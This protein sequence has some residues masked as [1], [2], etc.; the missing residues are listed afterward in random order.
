MWSQSSAPLGFEVQVSQLT[1][2]TCV[3]VLL[4]GGAL[5]GSRDFFRRIDEKAV[6]CF[7]LEHVGISDVRRQVGCRIKKTTFGWVCK[8]GP[9]RRRNGKQELG[10]WDVDKMGWE[11]R[12]DN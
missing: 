6:S 8:V 12:E 7:R 4:R 2:E 3:K 11:I 9:V 10:K 5:V 1:I